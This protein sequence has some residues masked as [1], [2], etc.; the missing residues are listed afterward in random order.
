MSTQAI[1][2]PYERRESPGRATRI[3]LGIFLAGVAAFYGL[4]VTILPP[5]A[6]FVPATP[7][8]LLT[9]LVLWMLPDLGGIQHEKLR[10]LMLLFLALSFAWPTYV[11]LDLPGLPWITP[12]RLVLFLMVTV[13]VFNLATSKQL[14]AQLWHDSNHIPHVRSLFWGFWLVTT[15]SLFVST[16]PIES[17]TKYFNNQIYWTM[18]FLLSCMLASKPGFVTALSKSFLISLFIVAAIGVNEARV[19][20]VIWLPYLPSFLKIDPVLLEKLISSQSRAGSDIYRDRGTFAVSLNFADYLAM[21]FPFALHA[22]ISTRKAVH[23]VLLAAGIVATFIAMKATDS[24]SAMVGLLLGSVIYIFFAAINR[25]HAVKESIV[26]SATL[27]SYPVIV[28]LVGT[29]VMT[30]GRLHTAVLGN[31]VTAAS[32]NARDLQWAMGIPKI[33]VH[34]LG[35]GT[36]H[37]GTVLGYAN[38]AGEITVDTWYLTALLDYGYFGLPLFISM[39]AIAAWFGLRAHA[40]AETTEQRL[41]APLVIGLLNFI[42]IASVFSNEQMFPYAFIM[43]GCVV[44]LV[45][46]QNGTTRLA[47]ADKP[48]T[49]RFPA[50]LQRLPKRA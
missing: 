32:S 21:M 3:V 19:Q 43:L 47:L 33:L 40:K 39:F 26:A 1:L 42:I 6:L 48:V 50:L 9:G 44:G 12:T 7:L 16:A 45:G 35:H 41:L 17:L 24:R 22:L 38:A 29:A 25:R 8:L 31:G 37:A 30:S 49:N 34:P 13:F 4:M 36:G 46:Q 20:Q 23:F 27:F 11:A 15:L 10:R 2:H 5:S 28:A 14:M 18:L